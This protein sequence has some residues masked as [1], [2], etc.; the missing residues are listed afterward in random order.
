MEQKPQKGVRRRAANDRL[1]IRL[2]VQRERERKRERE[3]VNWKWAFNSL[4]EHGRP[5]DR[6]R[7]TKHARLKKG[8]A[9]QKRDIVRLR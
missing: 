7:K 2:F 1:I 9:G 4:S 3:R 5:W 8:G 6:R